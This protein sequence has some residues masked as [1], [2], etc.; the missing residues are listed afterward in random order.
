M[1]ARENF[2]RMLEG[3]EPRWMPL[4][5]PVTEPVAKA[6]Q[7]ATGKNPGEAFDTDFRQL[8]FAFQGQDAARWRL[9]LEGIGFRFPDNSVTSAFGISWVRPRPGSVGSAVHLL[10]MIHPL[11]GIDEVEALQSLPWPDLSEPSHYAGLE[12]VVADIRADGKVAVGACECTIFEHTWYLRGMD[13]VFCDWADEDPVTDWLLDYFTKRSVHLCRAFVRAGC[14]L[15]RLGDDVGSQQSLLLSVDMWRRHLK[16]RLKRVMDAIREESGDRKVWV[17]YH[18]D[19]AVG[20]LVPEWIELG[21]DILNPVQPECMDLEALASRY[22]DQIAFCG[23]IGT[24]TTMPFGSVGDVHQ[25][26]HRCRSLYENGSRVI[27]APTH[28]LEPDVPMQ[29]IFALVEAAKKPLAPRS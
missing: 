18:S 16:P 25:A 21:I 10:E 1:D 19:G 4:D 22:S 2:S 17:Q 13:N 9:A 27:V 11:A 8:P 7:L 23:M 6:V 15:I 14:D 29:N 20:P 3:R 28:V 24:Q 26:V 5:L 12:K